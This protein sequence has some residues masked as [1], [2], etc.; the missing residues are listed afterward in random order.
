M[1]QHWTIEQSKPLI[2]SPWI[3]VYEET[4]KTDKGHV[5]TPFY[6]IEEPDWAC[7]VAITPSNKIVLVKQ[8]RRGCSKVLLELP[9]G[10]IDDDD[11]EKDLQKTAI[12]ELT[13]ETGY[14]VDVTKPILFLGKTL[15][16]CN[17]NSSVA[18]GYLVHVTT[19][20]PISEQSLDANED[21]HVVLVDFNEAYNRFCLN[22]EES[23]SPCH[24]TYLFRAFIHLN[25]IK[26]EQ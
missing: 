5:I 3:S 1:M 19:E 22:Y 4:V 25:K 8:Y 16:D 17:R 20:E 10:A 14:V 21:I 2:Q 18:Y 9:G 6:F 15:P 26:F 13:E 23:L 12:R 24:V 11:Q 7:V